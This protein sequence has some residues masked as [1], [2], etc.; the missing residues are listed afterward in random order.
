MGEAD[1]AIERGELDQFRRLDREDAA[2]QDFL[3]VLGALGRAVDHEHGRRGR[4]HIE[5]ADERLLADEAREGAGR[6]E[7]RGTE[8]GEGESVGKA[9][10]AHRRVAE[11][12]GDGGAERR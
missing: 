2:D 8:R 5:D 10:R 9:R 3:D 1:G 12:K 6:G 4:R 7:E 11:R